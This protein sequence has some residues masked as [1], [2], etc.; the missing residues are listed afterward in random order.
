MDFA[1]SQ[2]SWGQSRSA[3][4]PAPS[5]GCGPIWKRRLLSHREKA[6]VIGDRGWDSEGQQT[7][8]EGTCL[9][10]EGEASWLPPLHWGQ[11]KGLEGGRSPASHPARP[12]CLTLRYSSMGTDSKQEFN[13]KMEQTPPA[14]WTVLQIQCCVC[15]M[16]CTPP[17]TV[18]KEGTQH[19]FIFSNSYTENMKNN[20]TSFHKIW[21]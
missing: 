15:E 12:H 9:S 7:S 18:H 11:S 2:S 20:N 13:L 1:S 4:S 6:S 14:S 19:K 10:Q 3:E 16:L 8:E 21:Y 5:R 17:S